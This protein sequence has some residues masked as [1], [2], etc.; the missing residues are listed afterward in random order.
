MIV[1]NNCPAST[2]PLCRH[3]CAYASSSSSCDDDGEY[4]LRMGPDDIAQA[5]TEC[6]SEGE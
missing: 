6:N 5:A 2:S 3:V 1:E 4:H